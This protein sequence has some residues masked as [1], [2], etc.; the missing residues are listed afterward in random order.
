MVDELLAIGRLLGRLGVNV[1]Q[2]ARVTNATGEQHPGPAAAME[3]VVRVCT[4]IEALVTEM[5]TARAAR[6]PRPRPPS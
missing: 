3:A 6:L 2:I 4:R 1:N 5:D